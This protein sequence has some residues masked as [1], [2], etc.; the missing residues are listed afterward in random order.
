MCKINVFSVSHRAKPYCLD[1]F[2]INGIVPKNKLLCGLYF[3]YTCTCIVSVHLSRSTS[4]SAAVL[5]R[6][7]SPLQSAGTTQF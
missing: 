2:D 4:W 1:L 7:L 3:D 6:K 5:P